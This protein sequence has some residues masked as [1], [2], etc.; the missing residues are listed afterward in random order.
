LYE[1]YEK[2]TENNKGD[3]NG[4]LRVNPNDISAKSSFFED[5]SYIWNNGNK[6]N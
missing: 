5:D 3:G 4:K 1:K 6:I 2:K